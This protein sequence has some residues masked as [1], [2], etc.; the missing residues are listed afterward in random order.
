M[1]STGG[2]GKLRASAPIANSRGSRI[3]ADLEANSR[4]LK[5]SGAD[6]MRETQACVFCARR[7]VTTPATPSAKLRGGAEA[8]RS[9]SV[10]ERAGDLILQGFEQV[11][12]R[13]S[14]PRLKKYLD[15]HA[16]YETN[17]L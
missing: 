10:P 4:S 6:G 9:L 2:S 12:E 1:A 7:S 11:R 3:D 14:R 16:R 8:K 13:T 17:V 5:S 15:G